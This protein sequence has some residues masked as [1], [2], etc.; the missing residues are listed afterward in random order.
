M[1]CRTAQR[2]M[3]LAVG[4]DLPQVESVEL[5]VHLAECTTCQQA[6]SQHQQSFSAL[7]SSRV[8]PV[9]TP[10]TTIWPVVSRRI[11]RRALIPRRAELNGWIASLVV[12]SASVLVF[13]FSQEEQGLLKISGDHHLV[14]GEIPVML[15]PDASPLPWQTGRTNSGGSRL[16]SVPHSGDL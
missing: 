10:R 16:S 6:W 3:A 2:Q 13:V 4:E 8:E 5:N 9:A 12:V 15:I 1:H 7:Q 14:V 11:Q